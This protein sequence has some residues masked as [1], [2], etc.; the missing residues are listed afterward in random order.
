MKLFISYTLRDGEV[1]ESL[2]HKIDNLNTLQNLELFIDKLHNT[3]M[4][5][6]RRIE[7]EIRKSDALVLLGSKGVFKS[8]WVK[9]EVLLARD[10]SLDVYL[11]QPNRVVEE[12]KSI[13]KR[14]NDIDKIPSIS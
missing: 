4:H 7:K 11:I 5:P 14:F 10:S 9:R 13:H 6:Q 1:N 3:D 8:D 12:I 2:L